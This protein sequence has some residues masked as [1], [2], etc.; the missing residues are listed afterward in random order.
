MIL[1]GP[2]HHHEQLIKMVEMGGRPMGRTDEC[3]CG[4]GG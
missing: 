3:R 2:L 4:Y 1:T